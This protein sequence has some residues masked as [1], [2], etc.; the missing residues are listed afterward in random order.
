MHALGNIPQWPLVNPSKHILL[1]TASIAGDPGEGS[2]TSPEWALIHH[3]KSMGVVHGWRRTS[4]LVQEENNNVTLNP[5]PN[6]TDFQVI[7]EIFFITFINLL[8]DL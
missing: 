7:Q 4:S 1:H 6:R 3:P 5:Q 8:I 2:C